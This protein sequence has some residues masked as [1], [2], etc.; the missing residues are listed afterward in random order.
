[1]TSASFDPRG[2]DAEPDILEPERASLLAIMALVFGIICFIPFLGVLGIVFGIAGLI[3]INRS[4]GRLAGTGMAIAGLILGLLFTALWGAIAIG[5]SQALG[6]VVREIVK[7][8]GQFVQAVDQK[9]YVTA[10]QVLDANAQTLATDEAF[11]QFGDPVRSELGAFKGI[12]EGWDLISAYGEIGQLF[13][14]AQNMQGPRRQDGMIPVPAR[15]ENG[16]ALLFIWFDPPKGN[17]P[18]PQPGTMFTFQNVTIITPS[19]KVHNLIDPALV[20]PPV[21]GVLPG[22]TPT[23]DPNAP[24]SD[25]ATPEPAP[26]PEGEKAPEGE[27]SGGGN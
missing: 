14:A 12:P 27:R 9:D 26:S 10:R 3:V 21:P 5:M 13:Q 4:R 6:Y 25:P 22:G 15:F 23:P 1:M 2:F 20:Q 24:P 19:L 18:A 11:A 16:N 8:T 7:P 17:K